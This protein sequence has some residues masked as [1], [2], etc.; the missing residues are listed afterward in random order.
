MYWLHLQ[1]GPLYEKAMDIIYEVSPFTIM[2]IEGCGQQGYPGLNWGDGFVTDPAYINRYGLSD[3]NP[4][5]GNLLTKPY[6]DNVGMTPHV[7]PPSIT[8]AT[9]VS[10][11][12]SLMYTKYS[13]SCS[14]IS[15]TLS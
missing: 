11:H 4:F 3:P 9:T 13:H 5:L 10:P 7:Y 8:F 14:T 2:M 6:L 1:M 12:D 15:A